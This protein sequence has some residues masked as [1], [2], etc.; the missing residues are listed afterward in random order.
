MIQK[1]R[2]IFYYVVE[3]YEII[4]TN[5]QKIETKVEKYADILPA[6]VVCR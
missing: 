5:K 2:S 1:L 4:C 3:N 6:N